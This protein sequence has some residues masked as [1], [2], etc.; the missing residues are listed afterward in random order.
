MGA[1]SL[2]L[3]GYDMI[4]VRLC[5]FGV[6]CIRHLAWPILLLCTKNLLWLGRCHVSNGEKD[7]ARVAFERVLALKEGSLE[8]RTAQQDAQEALRAL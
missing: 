1:L 5:V 8:D 3:H 6:L 4:A 7:E 2:C